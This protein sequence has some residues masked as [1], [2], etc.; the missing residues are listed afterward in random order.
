MF[1]LVVD[2]ALRR[3][4]CRVALCYG[5]EYTSFLALSI[6]REFIAVLKYKDILLNT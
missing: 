1:R 6:R 3:N 2:Y 4:D 5:I